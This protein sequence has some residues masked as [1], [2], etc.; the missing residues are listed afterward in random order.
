MSELHPPERRRTRLVLI[1][2]AGALLAALT[3]VGVAGLIV[4][5][6]TPSETTPA[7]AAPPSSAEPGDPE[8]A[9]V[10]DLPV[11]ADPVRYATA[12]ADALFAWDT[13]DGLP[14]DTYLAA[15]H[16]ATAA[17]G[18]E[19]NG[20]YHDL[21]NYLPDQDAWAQL[22]GMQAR[23]WLQVD[24]AAIPA[25]WTEAAKHPSVG[26]DTVAITIDGTRHRD[27]LWNGQPTATASPV[28]FTLFLSCPP[29]GRCSLLRLT[30]PD[31]PLR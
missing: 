28:A 5:P 4:G 14:P 12:V 10:L 6:P 15:L 25:G 29:D 1:I 16:E 21:D 8:E 24:N 3:V 23:Q 20:L 19:A 9:G 18:P 7:P 22:A 11:T 13:R 26:E 30:L 27:G 2:V 17:E 31:A